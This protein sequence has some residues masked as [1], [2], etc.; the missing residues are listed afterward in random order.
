MILSSMILTHFG[1]KG[2]K[3]KGTKKEE[4]SLNEYYS[5]QKHLLHKWL[6]FVKQVTKLI[7]VMFDGYW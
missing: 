3:K 6:E 1:A 5:H 7:S 4:E 2:K